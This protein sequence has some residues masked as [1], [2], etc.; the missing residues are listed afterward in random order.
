MMMNIVNYIFL[1]LQGLFNPANYNLRNITIFV[2][3]LMCIQYIPIESRAGVSPVKVA[4]MSIMPFVL[5]SHFRVNKAVILSF[6]YMAWV[7]FTAAILHP[8]TFRLS[9]VLYNMMFLITFVVIYTAVWDYSV[10][11][12]SDFTVFLRMLFFVLVGFLLAQQA[13]L[14]IGIRLMP[15]LN[16]CQILERGIGANSLTYEPSTLGRLLTIIYYSI[17]KCVEFKNGEKVRV[18]DVFKGDLKWISILYVWSVITMGS[19]T[20]FVAAGILS[21]Y[22]LQGRYI[23]LAVPIFLGLYFIMENMENKSFTRAQNA[24]VAAL[25]GDVNDVKETDTS[26]STRIAPILNTLHADISQT[27]FWIGRGCDSFSGSFAIRI[28]RKMGHID[29]YGF[30]SFVLEYVFAYF[31]MINFKSIEIIFF[32]LGIGGGFGNIPY[33]WGIVMILTC[34]K[35]FNCHRDMIEEEYR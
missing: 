13:C 1:F 35:Y 18:T 11:S 14:S 31:C 20:A 32:I 4:T 7:F 2:I 23:F 34:V 6:I 9:T 30:I 22:F 29:D 12:L 5:L 26:A 19:G 21:L 27:E 16:L 10:F 25:T 15:I 8:E 17:L 28:N 33:G 24:S 3:V